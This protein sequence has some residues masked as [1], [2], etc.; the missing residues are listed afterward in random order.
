MPECNFNFKIVENSIFVLVHSRP[1]TVGSVTKS[2]FIDSST[3]YN[4]DL[5]KLY[6][7]KYMYYI[8]IHG[9]WGN[10]NIGYTESEM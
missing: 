1:K 3:F 10:Y 9:F 5:Y 7:Q 6:K 4:I 8:F 2:V